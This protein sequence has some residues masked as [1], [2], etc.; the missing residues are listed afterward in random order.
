MHV[1]HGAFEPVLSLP[2]HS[3]VRQRGMVCDCVAVLTDC[4][5]F[6]LQSQTEDTQALINR[7]PQF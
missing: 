4:P 5:T 7:G 3:I 2:F 6:K 1:V